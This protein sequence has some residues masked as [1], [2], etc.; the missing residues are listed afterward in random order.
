MPSPKPSLILLVTGLLTL[1]GMDAGAQRPIDDGKRADSLENIL[2]TSAIDTVRIDAMQSLSNYW[3]YKD[4]AKAME[5]ALRSGEAS[6]K[7]RDSFH[8]ALSYFYTGNVYMEHYN[9]PKA[10]HQLMTAEQLLRNDSSYRGLKYRAR[11]WHNSRR[12]PSADGRQQ[13][14]PRH[15]AEQ[16]RAVAGKGGRFGNACP[17]L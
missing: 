16:G 13:T 15:H 9:L 5:Y 10:A 1:T 14:V 2:R 7:I 6:R 3:L 4:S 12:Y 17:D 8:I 11:I